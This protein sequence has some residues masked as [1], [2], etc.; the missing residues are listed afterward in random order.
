MEVGMCVNICVVVQYIE[1]WI[2]GNG[3]V[4]IYGLMEDVVMVEILC[5]FIWQWIY[6]Q[7]I[8]NDGILV[9]KVLFCQWLVEEL[10]VIQEELGEYCFSYG[11]FDDVV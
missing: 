9:I 5:I 6:Y 4:L 11:C 10:M 2:F 1:V 7:K 8:L 3:C